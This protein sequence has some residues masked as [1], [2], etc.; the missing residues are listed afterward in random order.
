MVPS[1]RD[2]EGPFFEPQAPNSY[3]L[4]PEEELA[5]PEEF[6]LLQG[7]VLDTD[8]RYTPMPLQ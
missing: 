8:R 6:V 1:P 2:V 5:D 7:Q 4:A 3:E